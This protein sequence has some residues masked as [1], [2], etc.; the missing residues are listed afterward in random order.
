MLFSTSSIAAD[1]LRPVIPP[2]DAPRLSGVRAVSRDGVEPIPVSPARGPTT[3][4]ESVP[5][6]SSPSE[7]PAFHA[8][9][10]TAYQ[11]NA[12]GDTAQLSSKLDQLTEA[13]QREVTELKRRDTE[14][15]T[16]EQAH[17]AA[18][19]PLFR[20]GPYYEYREGPDG[21][22]YAV[23]GRVQ[24][25]TSKGRTPEE[26]LAKAA[27]IRAAALAPAD[28]SSTDRAV[29]AKAAQ[30]EAQARAELSKARASGEED[31]DTLR[32]AAPDKSQPSAFKVATGAGDLRTPRLDLYG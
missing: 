3:P 22:R 19:G 32:I 29:A 5:G 18:A 15:R 13:E 9:S 16:H 23:G 7:R 25:D 12:D 28:P 14:V 31:D 21:N 2:M 11:S 8:R 26:T 1:G 6:R 4:R 27:K 30:M 20:G 17:V 24:I 10:G